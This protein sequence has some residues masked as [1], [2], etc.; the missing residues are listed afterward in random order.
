MARVPDGPAVPLQ[1]DGEQVRSNF[2]GHTALAAFHVAAGFQRLTVDVDLITLARVEL[3]R[4]GS[5]EGVS[6][7]DHT[8][9]AGFE[10][11]ASCLDACLARAAAGMF[12]MMF[13]PPNT[14]DR[15]SQRSVEVE[16]GADCPEELMVSWLEELLYRSEV[17]EVFFLRF[18]VETVET[19]GLRL[20]G[21]AAGVP[22]TPDLEP[23]GPGVKAVTRHGLRVERA[24]EGWWARVIFDV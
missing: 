6:L 14:M 9:D 16:L 21:R 20:S 7:I 2:A 15:R 11:E 23:A 12:A 3:S 22:I 24:G 10:V 17:E 19:D 4:A 1:S 5:V 13:D 8:A 18:D